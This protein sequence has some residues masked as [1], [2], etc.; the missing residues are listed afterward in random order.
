MS[1][2]LDPDDED[3][4]LTTEDALKSILE[5]RRH[6][7]VLNAAFKTVDI[8]SGI[9]KKRLFLKNGKQ[10]TT[11]LHQ[12][13]APFDDPEVYREVEHALAHVLFQ[14]DP[15]AKKM[16]I[17][18]YTKRVSKVLSKH[19]VDLGPNQ[20]KQL[21]EGLDDLINITEN[22]RV[23]S[24]WGLIY[25]GSYRL[26]RQKDRDRLAG[27]LT[28]AHAHGISMFYAVLE[29]GHD[30]EDG[31]LDRYRPYCIEALRKVEKR[32]FA[33]T[34]MVSKW[35]V[36][37]LVSEI[38]R[39]LKDEPPPQPPAEMPNTVPDQEDCGFGGRRP[40]PGPERPAERLSGRPGRQP[41]GLRP[42]L[43]PGRFS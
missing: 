27:A 9:T 34:L 4:W 35:L 10:T 37:N 40:R 38:I 24:L 25:P 29:S 28:D 14:T 3:P 41:G 13:T 11:D 30:P 17:E 7:L 42:G 1:Y 32:G 6:T 36:A 31:E 21:S 22:H 33:A 12:I 2:F 39:E 8:F 20:T 16:F 15:V 5:T 19:G 26:M 23:N 18:E 43:G